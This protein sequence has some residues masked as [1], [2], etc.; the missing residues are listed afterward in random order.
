[1]KTTYEGISQEQLIERLEYV[2]VKMKNE[3]NDG[4]VQQANYSVSETH[5]SVVHKDGYHTTYV[6][7]QTPQFTYHFDFTVEVIGD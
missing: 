4:V 2:L 1:M 5:H 6:F 3:Y 7:K